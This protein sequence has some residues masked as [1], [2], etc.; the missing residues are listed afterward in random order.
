MSG[1][2]C[3][4][5]FTCINSH[6]SHKKPM[7]EIGVIIIVLILL[8]KKLGMPAAWAR[9]LGSR[10]SSLHH[11]AVTS[12]KDR[13]LGGKNL[14]WGTKSDWTLKTL[15]SCDSNQ[16]K[17]EGSK[18]RSERQAGADS[19]VEPYEKVR[20]LWRVLNSSVSTCSTRMCASAWAA[21][22]LRIMHI[23]SR[24][25]NSLV[26]RKPELFVQS[27]PF[28]NPMSSFWTSQPIPWSQSLLMLWGRPSMSTRVL[29]QSQPSCMTHHRNQ[30]ST[31]SGG[32]AKCYLNWWGLWGL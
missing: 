5:Y 30:L 3:P 19:H 2:V 24:S 32:G 13:N 26:G 4:N 16:K 7:K 20:N 28:G 22:A 15:E 6:N 10:V 18:M 8:M 11:N 31:V 25:A 23:P 1:R 21:L 29:W 17:E 9:Q 27:W 12:T 14:P